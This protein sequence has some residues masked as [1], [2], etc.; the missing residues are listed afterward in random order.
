MPNQ[1]SQ[2]LYHVLVLL[3][4]LLCLST[5]LSAAVIYVNNRIGADAFDGASKKPIGQETGPVKTIRRALQLA[6]SADTIVVENTGTA[7]Y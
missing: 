7:Y 2:R 6:E 1:L 5:S 4:L 3:T